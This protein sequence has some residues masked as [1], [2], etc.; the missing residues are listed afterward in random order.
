MTREQLA[1]HRQVLVTRIAKYQ[2]L[3]QYAGGP[4]VDV[5]AND[6]IADLEDKVQTCKDYLELGAGAAFVPMA[7]WRALD[8][9]QAFTF[10]PFNRRYTRLDFRGVVESAQEVKPQ[11]DDL[12]EELAVDHIG[13]LRMGT[14][15][16][17]GLLTGMLL[18]NQHNLN[19]NPALAAAVARAQAPAPQ[20]AAQAAMYAGI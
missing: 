17:L 9:A 8:F 6:S 13:V 18:A 19:T 11:I 10:T 15:K 16:R 1:L 20:A 14:G 7:Y 4:A 12:L 5:R 3:R 2:Q